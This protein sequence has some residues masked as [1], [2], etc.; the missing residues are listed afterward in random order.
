MISS[1]HKLIK[2]E[3]NM[4]YGYQCMELSDQKFATDH[5]QERSGT[6]K[7]NRQKFGFINGL[8]NVNWPSYKDSKS[9]R[10]ERD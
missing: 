9:W 1:V 10:F 2:Y 3:L 6:L 4:N 8:Y 7:I 5:F